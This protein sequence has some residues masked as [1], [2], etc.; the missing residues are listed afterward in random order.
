EVGFTVISMSLSLIAVFVPFQLAGGIVGKLFREFTVTL[1]VAILISLVISLTT[2]PMMC[3]RLLG[4]D[5]QRRPNRLAAAFERQFQ[6]LREGYERTL[7]WSLDHR[8][9]ML[10][11]LLATVCLNVYLYVVIPKGFFPQQ[12]TGTI[13]GGIRGDADTSFQLMKTKLQDVAAIIQ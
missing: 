4:R 2:T 3:A 1:S 5:R 9:L 7:N 12:D 6:R 8:R 11:F 13:F 10:F